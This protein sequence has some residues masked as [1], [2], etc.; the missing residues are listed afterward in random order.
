MTT[1]EKNNKRISCA[2]ELLIAK[3]G[4]GK[5]QYGWKL[6]DKDGFIDKAYSGQIAAFSVSVAMVG[7]KPT[8]AMFYQQGGSSVNTHNIVGLIAE[9]LVAEGYPFEGKSPADKFFDHVMGMPAGKEA[10][11]LRK[12]VIDNAVALKVVVR[13][14]L[15]SENDEESA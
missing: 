4:D 11:K 14:F 3:K 15:K 7:L 10:D 1:K 9:M 2:F 5:S 6:I 12:D 13:T 8:L